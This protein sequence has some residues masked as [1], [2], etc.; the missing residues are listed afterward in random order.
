MFSLWRVL[1]RNIFFPTDVINV[2]GEQS[3]PFHG[4]GIIG[5]ESVLV[6]ARPSFVRLNTAQMGADGR[7]CVVRCPLDP[8]PFR[9][10]PLTDVLEVRGE[11]QWSEQHTNKACVTH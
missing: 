10:P 3:S 1:L 7:R 4:A 11:R 8:S 2:T 9:L 5:C 6:S